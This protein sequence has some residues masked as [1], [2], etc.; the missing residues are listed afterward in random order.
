M[1]TTFVIKGR[2]GSPDGSGRPYLANAWESCAIRLFGEAMTSTPNQARATVLVRRPSRDGRPP[3]PLA[4]LVG[5]RSTCFTTTTSRG[6]R[7]CTRGVRRDVGPITRAGE[8]VVGDVVIRRPPRRRSVG[9]VEP[10]GRGENPRSAGTIRQSVMALRAS[11]RAE[12]AATTLVSHDAGGRRR[13]WRRRPG[14]PSFR[15]AP[16]RPRSCSQGESG[17]MD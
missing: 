6:C 16:R 14:Y 8:G 4:S 1:T 9:S 15:P 2:I 11:S 5:N 7:T 10:A 13:S 3:E 17:L 12:S